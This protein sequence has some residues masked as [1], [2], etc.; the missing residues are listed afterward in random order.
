MPGRS[1]VEIGYNL[2]DSIP[3]KHCHLLDHLDTTQHT[4]M[5]EI[6]ETKFGNKSLVVRDIISQI[7]KTKSISSDKAFIEFVEQLEKIKLD[8]ETLGQISE[9]ANAGYI[10]K[11][12]W[13]LPFCISTDWWKI[14]EDE[15]L[16]TKLINAVSEEVKEE[17]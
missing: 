1:D 10:G 3:Q 14:V 17:S 15:D 2:R 11:I 8:L 6:L 13:R 5:M 9:V 12:E 16:D 7:E 4:E